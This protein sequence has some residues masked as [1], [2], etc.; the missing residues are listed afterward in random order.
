MRL[1][2]VCDRIFELSPF[3]LR[4]GILVELQTLESVPQIQS[5]MFQCNCLQLC[6]VE[7]GWA[8]GDT[9]CLR[10]KA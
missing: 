9:R 4:G 3:V 5:K 6:R 2:S 1:G 7:L 10:V 8:V